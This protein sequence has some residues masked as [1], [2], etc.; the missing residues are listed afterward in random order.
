MISLSSDKQKRHQQIRSVLLSIDDFDL[1]VICEMLCE[2]YTNK[3]MPSVSA[4]LS[5]IKMKINFPWQEETL[6]RILHE[7]DFW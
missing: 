4:L 6:Q 7:I 2:F 1:C 3:R 5:V